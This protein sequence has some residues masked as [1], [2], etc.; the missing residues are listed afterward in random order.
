VVAP[1]TQLHARGLGVLAVL[2][3]P[4]PFLRPEHA[5]PATVPAVASALKAGDVAVRVIGGEPDWERTLVR[6]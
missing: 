3:D 2:I 1:L 5:L 4:T 6:E